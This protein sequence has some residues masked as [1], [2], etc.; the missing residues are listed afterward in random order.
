MNALRITALIIA[1]SPAIAFCQDAPVIAPIT[2]ADA[3]GRPQL[4]G[5]LA[6]FW[7]G[8]LQR[9]GKIP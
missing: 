8:I 5:L 9:G 6:V 3:A 1:L 4:V 7:H 2:P